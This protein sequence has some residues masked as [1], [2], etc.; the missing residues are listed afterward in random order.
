MER[1]SHGGADSF[2]RGKA[3]L[4]IGDW[5]FAELFDMTGLSAEDRA[6]FAQVGRP[7]DSS[8]RMDHRLDQSAA[9]NSFAPH[10]IPLSRRR[11]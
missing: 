6:T 9:S 8:R 10:S 2:F 7:R 1:D 11:A 4:D 5:T 3:A